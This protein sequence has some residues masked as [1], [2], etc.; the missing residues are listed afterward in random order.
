MNYKGDI[1]KQR[2]ENTKR[3]PQKY[4]LQDSLFEN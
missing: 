3:L 2:E 4:N 1:N